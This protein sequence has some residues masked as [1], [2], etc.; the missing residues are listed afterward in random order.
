MIISRA[1]LRMSFLGGGTDF[2]EYFEEHGGEVISTAIDKFSYVSINRLLGFFDHKIRLSY[3]KTELVNE[4]SEIQHPAVRAA[5]E[6]LGIRSHIEIN[7]ISD[8]PA[9]TGLGS[10]GSFVV[11]LLNAL[12]AMKGEYISPEKLGHEAIHLEQNILK[13]HVG[14]QDQF[15]AAIGGFNRISFHAKNDIRFEPIVMSR[16]RRCDLNCNLLMYY[17]G[18]QRS[19]SEIQSELVKNS[20]VNVP[21]LNDLKGLVKEAQKVLQSGRPL[22]EF[23]V[24]L[25]EGWKLK[26]SLSKLVSNGMIEEMYEAGKKAGA[27]GG[28]LLG[29]GGGGFLLLYVDKEYHESVRNALSSFREVAFQFEDSGSQIVYHKEGR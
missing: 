18:L 6:S 15:A 27:K 8:L 22:T 12:H 10:S 25:D 3:S 4:A 17:T 16:A 19:S 24:L 1:P 20:K 5:L 13:D 7:C 2:P 29:A 28:K 9:R 26:R 14:S 23:G 21:Y 11:A